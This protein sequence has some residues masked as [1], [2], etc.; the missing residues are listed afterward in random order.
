MNSSET[1]EKAQKFDFS[2][3]VVVGFDKSDGQYRF[4][5]NSNDPKVV[6]WLLEITKKSIL[7]IKEKK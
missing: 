2:E 3:V 5:C 6:L 1:L 7:S 4:F